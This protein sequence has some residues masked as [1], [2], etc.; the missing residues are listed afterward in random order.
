MYDTVCMAV[1]GCG[2][3]LCQL[4][5][6]VKCKRIGE[7]RVAEHDEAVAKAAKES[8]EPEI[9]AASLA[10]NRHEYEPPRSVSSALLIHDRLTFASVRAHV[11]SI[12]PAATLDVARPSPH[13]RKP[14]TTDNADDT[15][16]QEWSV[17]DIRVIRAIRGL[18]FATKSL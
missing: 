5:I 4:A 3:L 13:A 16:N 1:Q 7:E 9:G 10:E 17:F 8:S 15:D 18:I 2:R 11:H 12:M 14:R 6:R